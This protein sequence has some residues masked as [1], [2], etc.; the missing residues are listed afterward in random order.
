MI[1]QYLLH[2]NANLDMGLVKSKVSSLPT[3]GMGDYD[4]YWLTT[5]NSI[6]IYCLADD[7]WTSKIP[8]NG[9]HFMLESDGKYYFCHNGVFKDVTSDTDAT[10]VNGHTIESDVPDNAIFTDTVYDDSAITQRVSDLEGTEHTHSNKVNIDKI[11]EDTNGNLTYNGEPIVSG[12]TSDYSTLS[13]KPNINGVEL[14]GSKTLSDLG[15]QPSGDY[16][17]EIPSE[18]VTDEELTSKNY[19]TTSQI[20]DISEKLES[21]NILA[22]TNVTLNKVGNNVTINASGGGT[23]GSNVTESVTN[24]NIVVDGSEV[25]VYTLPSDIAKTSDIPTITDSTVNGNL[26]VNGAEITVYELP[27]DV[28]K[29]SDIPSVST[30][31]EATNIKAGTNITIDTIGNDVTI[32][33][34]DGINGT[35]GI[36]PT[37]VANVSNTDSIY[38]LDITDVNGTITTP[39]LKGDKG[40]T[41]EQGLQGTVDTSFTT[42]TSFENIISGE[43]TSTLF[44]KIAKWFSI[45]SG[46]L[47]K[48]SVVQTNVNNANTVPS[49]A[50]TYA[51]YQALNDG[52]NDGLN[53]RV[54]FFPEGDLTADDINYTLNYAYETTVNCW[55]IEYQAIGLSNDSFALKH[56]PIVNAGTFVGACQEARSVTALRRRY[57]DGSSWSDWVVV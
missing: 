33:S 28:A 25:V 5:D 46:K 44:G 34:T 48:S 19:A 38:K 31:L 47:D 32:N 20:P 42:A 13:N 22:G 56:M 27:S 39:N 15:I 49:S 3:S 16:L 52:L 40:D 24:G 10:T 18:Y 30:K 45:I 26:S 37:I 53:R 17:T 11:G 41:G 50:L 9:M 7:A 43:T 23:S 21:S 57:H 6:N 14:T 1:N 36:S 35:N 2:I 8:V 54:R 12:G 55:K 51:Q 4:K 29:T